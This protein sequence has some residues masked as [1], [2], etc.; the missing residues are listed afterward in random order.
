MFVFVESILG[1]IVSYFILA[2]LKT[3][4]T[5]TPPVSHEPLPADW[6]YEFE[7]GGLE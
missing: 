6:K 5:P 2:F 3:F 4:D 7:D 1:I